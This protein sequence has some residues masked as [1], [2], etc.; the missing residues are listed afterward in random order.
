[1]PLLLPLT[2]EIALFPTLYPGLPNFTDLYSNF[3]LSRFR[4]YVP[5]LP[6]R[7]IF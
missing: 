6:A 1:M 4:I 5:K 3:S 2:S 7:F